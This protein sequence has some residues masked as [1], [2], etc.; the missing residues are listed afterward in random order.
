MARHYARQ[1]SP[2]T[3]VNPARVFGPELLT[4]GNSV[5]R[6]IQW[7]L[8][9]RWRLLPA[10]D[11]HANWAFIDDV[12]RGHLLA[13]EHGAPGQRYVLGGENASLRRLFDLIAEISGRRYRLFPVPAAAARTAAVI[14]RS[15]AE[16]FR[17]YPLITP[18]WVRCF[19]RDWACASAKAEREIGYSVTPL[20]QALQKTIESLSGERKEESC[21]TF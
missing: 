16:W 4:E 3:I 15:R 9:G 6:M 14:E 11:R 17:H 5:T 21:A 2:V 13:M 12:V 7:Y 10:G 19:E 8:A 20:R 1:G 18:D